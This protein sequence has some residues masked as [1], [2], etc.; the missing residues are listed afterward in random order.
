MTALQLQLDVIKGD[1]IIK[2]KAEME[3]ENKINTMDV[4]IDGEVVYTLEVN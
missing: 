4:I 2:T 1:R 3:L